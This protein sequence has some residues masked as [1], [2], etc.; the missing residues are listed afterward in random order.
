VFAQSREDVHGRN[1]RGW[2]VGTLFAMSSESPRSRRW[3]LL[4][5]AG[6]LLLLV[7]GA[8]AF[9]GTREPGDVSNPDVE[10]RAEPT[11]TPVPT[12]APTEPDKADDFV[13]PQ[14]GLTGDRRRYLP[15][16]KSL[17]PPFHHVWGVGGRGLIEFAPVIAGRAL[18]FVR[19]NGTV[20]AMAKRTGRI[21]WRKDMGHLAAASPAYGDKVIYVAVLER[22]KGSGGLVA[23]LRTKDGKVLWRR[24]LPSRTESSPVIDG[25]RIYLGSENGTVYSL[26]TSDGAVRWTFKAGGAVKGGP[27]LANGRL[28]FGDYGGRLYAVRQATGGL[29][30]RASSGGGRLGGSGNFYSTPAVAFGRVYIGN[31]DGRI[32]SYSASSGKLAWARKTGGYV[33]AS[34][35]VANIPGGEPTVYAG[36][37]DGRFYALDARN[38]RT[39]WTFNAGGRISG[40]ATVVGDLVYFADLGNRRTL[41]LGVRTGRKMFEYHRGGY[42]PV[43][44]DGRWIFLVGYTG[45]HAFRP[46]SEEGM[47]RRAKAARKARRARAATRKTAAARTAKVRKACRERAREAHSRSGAVRRSTDRCVNRRKRAGSIRACRR[48]ARAHERRAAQL[49]SYRR[50]LDARVRR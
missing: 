21:L 15:A 32:Y 28:Y 8:G 13:W 16:S 37:Y 33:Y 9:L 27:A 30:W 4:G 11:E 3:I 49:R 24:P 23:A 10:F 12:P 6:A 19:N 50:C 46:V 25:D 40:G 44:S 43:V 29:V 42:N 22:T 31:T 41:G 7:G 36:S 26:R 1:D 5:V 48:K 18:F 2:G 20:V 14:Y 34:P 35:A 17:R 38:G 45:V 39:V 47:E